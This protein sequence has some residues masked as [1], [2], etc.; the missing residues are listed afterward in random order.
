MEAE[1]SLAV[2]SSFSSDGL[3]NPVY[4]VIISL[5]LL[6]AWI[7]PL[8]C[9][10]LCVLYSVLDSHLPGGY[11][12][13]YLVSRIRTLS[14]VQ[15]LISLR[16][17]GEVIRVRV[18]TALV[19]L[20]AHS[21]LLVL[22]LLPILG[23]CFS[24]EDWYN[25]CPTFGSSFS[26]EYQTY[27]D[28]IGSSLSTGR[29]EDSDPKLESQGD[30]ACGNRLLPAPS[31]VTAVS[32]AQPLVTAD[33][34]PLVQQLHT[35][36]RDSGYWRG[37]WLGSVS[38]HIMYR[39]LLYELVTLSKTHLQQIIRTSLVWSGCS[40]FSYTNPLSIIIYIDQLKVEALV[41]TGA[42]YDAIDGE[43]AELLVR[44]RCPSFVS[45]TLIANRSVSGFTESL[46]TST[47]AQSTWKITLSGAPVF[48]GTT[49]S[50]DVFIACYEFAS[51]SD[52]LILGM[53][54][55]DEYGGLEV[56]EKFIWYADL[57]I[58]RHDTT[59]RTGSVASLRLEDVP[60]ATSGLKG[61]RPPPAHY[62]IDDKGWYVVP[63]YWSGSEVG[64]GYLFH[65]AQLV[66]HQRK[67]LKGC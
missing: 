45:R 57:W 11:P 55:I 59:K 38:C 43:L 30:T 24:P 1:F 17:S 25:C 31:L 52:P 62:I 54:S 26:A 36:R 3:G 47:K 67:V 35:H 60:L 32:A 58:P 20:L 48:Q 44:E 46:Q 39:I 49:I 14:P 53:P 18:L 42:D 51:L 34:S 33:S 15:E 4:A 22:L 29:A 5:M 41:D 28:A 12:A 6:A 27:Y 65:P 10:C 13:G 63:T 19:S 8:F 56:V 37:G 7:A 64:L 23:T 9:I 61:C 40:P 16:P 66:N 50:K 21:K 2:G